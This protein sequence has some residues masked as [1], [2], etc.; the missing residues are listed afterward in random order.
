MSFFRFFEAL[1]RAGVGGLEPPPEL[2]RGVKIFLKIIEK[3][4]CRLQGK[5][6]VTEARTACAKASEL[7]TEQP[8]HAV[9]MSWS[10]MYDIFRI[11]FRI[12]VGVWCIRFIL[13][14]STALCTLSWG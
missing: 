6:W 7:A 5:M 8:T 3:G 14:L 2:L 1:A 4:P 10:M 11:R 13:C 9:Y 12:Y